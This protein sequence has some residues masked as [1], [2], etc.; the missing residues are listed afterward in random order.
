MVPGLKFSSTT[1]ALAAS[2]RRMACPSGAFMLRVRLFLLRLTERKYVASPPVKGGQPRVSSPLP[3]SSTLMTSAPMS[4]SDIEQNGPASTR[5]RSMTRMPASGGRGCRFTGAFFLAVAT[6]SSSPDAF[7]QA[8]GNGCDLLTAG[9]GSTPEEPRPVREAHVG[10]G[11]HIVERFDAHAGADPDAARLRSMA[12][13]PS[14]ALELDERDVKRRLEPFGRRVQRRE[15]DDF[16]HPGHAGRFHGDGMIGAVA[17]RGHD[18]ALTARA[19]RGRDGPD[20]HARASSSVTQLL[21]ARPPM[22]WASATRAA[23]CRPSAMP[24]SCQQSSTIW[25]MP[26]AASGWP[27]ALSPPDGL[28]GSRPSSAVSPSR[29]ARPALPAGRRPGASSE[30]SS[31]GEKASWTSA[32]SMRSGPKPAIAYAARA[33]A[34]VARNEVRSAR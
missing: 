24:R 34:W 29:V 15:G 7:G 18:H 27:R 20:D 11:K 1:S 3:G 14:A 5:V 10:E 23:T 17:R 8:L 30:M 33:A 26:V 19:A 28:T 22:D 12:E 32:T 25:E 2:L 31:K 4:P 21:V 6:G 16:P 9:T 13:E